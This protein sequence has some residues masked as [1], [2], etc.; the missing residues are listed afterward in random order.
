MR[1]TL[2]LVLALSAC[3]GDAADT[4]GGPDRVWALHTLNE[5]PFAAPATLTFPKAGEISG[6][7]PC[8]RYFGALNSSYPAFSAGPIGSTRRAC[9]E[10]AAEAIFFEALQA[11]TQAFRKDGTLVLSNPDGLE[12]VF[13]AAE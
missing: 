6:Q 13:K 9:P 5:M 3:R 2:F 7:G 10:L 4:F 12:M 1:A 11:A 8:N